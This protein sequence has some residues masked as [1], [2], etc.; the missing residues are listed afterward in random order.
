MQAAPVFAKSTGQRA[1]AEVPAEV[2]AGVTEGY[3]NRTPC[4]VH[5]GSQNEQLHHFYLTAITLFD[6]VNIVFWA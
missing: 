5:G 2:P 6:I 3:D 4:H 1:A